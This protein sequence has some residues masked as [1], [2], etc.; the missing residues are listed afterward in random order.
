MRIAVVTGG[1]AD[2]GLLT[3]L[4][5]RLRDDQRFT[6]D[7]IVTGQHL[8]PGS[9]SLKQ[10]HADGFEVAETVDIL[11]ASDTGLAV[12][13]SSGLAAIGLADAFRRRNP[14]LVVVLGDRY[15]IFAAAFVA[16]LMRIPV[17][18]IAGGDVTEGAFDDG[19]RHAITKLSHLH[20]VTNVDAARRIRQLGENESTIHLVGS[21]GLDLIRK[22]KIPDRA[23]FF[24][25]VGLTPRERNLLVTFHPV[26]ARSDSMHQV[27]E[28]LAALDELGEGV[29]LVFTGVNADPE[30]R[31]IERVIVDFCS[32]H[33]NAVLKGVL[34]AQLYFGALTHCDAVVGNSSSGLYEAP[35]FRRPTVNIGDRQKGRLKAESV[36][37]C[38]PERSQISAAIA[39]AFSLDCRSVENP[40]G[41][42]HAAERIVE[43]LAAIDNPRGLLLKTFHD[44]PG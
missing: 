41:D 2:Y 37:D 30:G 13:K 8:V 24:A 35:S 34:G 38:A 16:Y 22:T 36:I 26:T 15:E 28:M 4:L 18:H 14:D 12:C 7:L 20:F 11:L 44:V 31:K 9:E 21:P 10:I 40:Y 23:S 32:S 39:R 5:R 17:A 33:S 1:R 19:L 27:A 42:G 43:V 29:G 6:F 25:I 3:V